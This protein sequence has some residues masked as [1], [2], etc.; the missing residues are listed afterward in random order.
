MCAH[1]RGAVGVF[2]RKLGNGG[3]AAKGRQRVFL[4]CRG[5]VLHQGCALLLLPFNILVPMVLDTILQTFADE[6]ILASLVHQDE[7]TGG[8]EEHAQP[9]DTARSAGGARIR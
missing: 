2:L 7:G 5:T 4:S 3:K 9:T 8:T 1:L 6:I